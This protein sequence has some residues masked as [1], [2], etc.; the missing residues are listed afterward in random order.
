M[1]PAHLVKAQV[2]DIR[3]S[4]SPTPPTLVV[5]ANVLYFVYY[6]NFQ[7]LAQAGGQVPR[8]YQLR[9]YPAWLKR[10]LTAKA[11]LLAAHQTIGELISLVEYA[12]LETLWQT[13]PKRVPGEKFARKQAR[14]DY[15]QQLT[16]TRASVVTIVQ[17]V[18]K[19]AALLPRPQSGDR[20]VDATIPVWKQSMTDWADA[21]F[22][23][24]AQFGSQ[25][26]VLSDDADLVTVNGIT[27]YTANNAAIDAAQKAGTLK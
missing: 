24:Q 5:D 19:P 13:D 15:E 7:V 14:Y 23:A 3:R 6:P 16:P 20:E 12:E 27:V 22:V 2:V 1:I 8:G 25:T 11:Q 21:V 4:T 26:S 18:R 9:Y 17:A 10:A